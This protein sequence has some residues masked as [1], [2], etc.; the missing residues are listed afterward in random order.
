[1]GEHKT[2]EAIVVRS[3]DVALKRPNV[4]VVMYDVENG[5][6]VSRDMRAAASSQ[7]VQTEILINLG[8]HQVARS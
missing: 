3:H 7:V 8:I 5:W 2:G 1:M 6:Q 4:A